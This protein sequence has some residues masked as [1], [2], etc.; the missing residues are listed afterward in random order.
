[1]P[2]LIVS[3]EPWRPAP[4]TG[5]HRSPPE[6][7]CRCEF[8]PALGVLP[9]RSGQFPVVPCDGVRTV[10]TPSFNRPQLWRPLAISAT[11]KRTLNRT[12]KVGP[13]PVETCSSGIERNCS[14]PVSTMNTDL[15]NCQCNTDC[16]CEIEA[17]KAVMR[18]GKAFCCEPCADGHRCGC[19]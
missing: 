11:H 13:P 9:G 19:R 14:I 4:A 5:T 1:M 15:I 6:P 17:E 12:S 16:Q 3:D 2:E 8:P 7:A 18:D 10:L